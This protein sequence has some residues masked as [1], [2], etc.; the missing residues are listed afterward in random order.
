MSSRFLCVNYRAIDISSSL[1]KGKTS[2]SL[3]ER[4]MLWEH[5]PQANVFTAFSSSHEIIIRCSA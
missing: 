1:S 2:G 3:G 4:E 5:E